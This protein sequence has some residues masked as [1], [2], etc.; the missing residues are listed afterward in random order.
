MY[1]KLYKSVG[2]LLSFL[3][4]NNSSQDIN[5]YVSFAKRSTFYIQVHYKL[6]RYIFYF[7]FLY[8]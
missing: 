3:S 1:L 2:T 8:I 5:K 6:N 4:I 7:N